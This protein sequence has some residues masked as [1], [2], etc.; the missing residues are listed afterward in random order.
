VNGRPAQKGWADWEEAVGGDEPILVHGEVRINTRDED[1]PRAEVVATEIEPLSAVRGQ[2][3]TQVAL[4]VDAD[5][6]TP[7]RSTQLKALLARFPGTTPVTVRAVIP[8]QTETTLRLP[9]RVVPAD[10][11]IEAARRLGFEVELL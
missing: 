3:T 11:F 2:K 6:L 5:A 8:E 9:A 1:H 7:E 10:E 4:R